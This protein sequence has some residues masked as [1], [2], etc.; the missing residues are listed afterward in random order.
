MLSGSRRHGAEYF[1]VSSPDDPPQNPNVAGKPSPIFRRRA[2]CSFNN[3]ARDNGRHGRALSFDLKTEGREV[4]FVQYLGDTTMLSR[5]NFSYQAEL[6]R[7]TKPSA[8][9]KITDGFR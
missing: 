6:Q 7:P 4:D 8:T 9:L 2:A 3:R 5:A 1:S